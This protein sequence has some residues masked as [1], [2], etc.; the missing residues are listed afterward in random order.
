MAERALT[1]TAATDRPTLLVLTVGGSPAPLRSSSAACR[2]NRALF[3]VS[4]SRDGMPGSGSEVEASIKGCEGFPEQYE[5]LAVPA[6]DPDRAFALILTRL[7]RAL[8]QG[9]HVI[10]DYTGG[11]KSMS[12][13]LMLAAAM[14]GGCDLRLMTGRRRDLRQVEDGTETPVDVPA[15]AVG[16]GR[17][18][19]SVANFTR[20]R[21]Y[22]A[23]LAVLPSEQA[24][25]ASLPAAWTRRVA[26]WRRWL[27]VMERW[28]RFDHAGA[29]KLVVRGQEV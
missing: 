11:T 7:E 23:A 10:A 24:V 26:L 20:Q 5:K 22:Q 16:L 8:A 18:L 2:P 1:G 9:H 27:T 28:D 3:I 25:P 19:V 13:A 4:E 12:G 21:A 17:V 29:L 14:T 15:E 6:D